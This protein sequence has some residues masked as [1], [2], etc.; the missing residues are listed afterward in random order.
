MTKHCGNLFDRLEVNRDAKV[1]V[2]YTFQKITK[3]Q[4]QPQLTLRIALI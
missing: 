4:Q 1:S 2:V 3:R